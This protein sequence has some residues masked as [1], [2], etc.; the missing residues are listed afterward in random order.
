MTA[1]TR[2]VWRIPA[3]GTRKQGWREN[4]ARLAVAHRNVWRSFQA[5]LRAYERKRGFPP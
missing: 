2:T 3:V 1:L 5:G 4:H